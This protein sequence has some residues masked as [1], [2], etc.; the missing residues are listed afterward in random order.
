MPRALALPLTFVTLFVLPACGP[1]EASGSGGAASSGS[2]Q[3]SGAGGQ[4]GDAGSGGVGGGGS[5][6]GGRGGAPGPSAWQTVL[7]AQDLDGAVLSIWGASH[8]HVF[9]VGGP[10]GNDGFET[11][12]VHFDGATWKR[13]S[14][15]GAETYWWVHGTG[16]DDVWFVGEQGR[17]THWDGASFTEH[18]S[19]V[20]AT[21]WG[22]MA[23]SKTEA[24]AV[25]GTPGGGVGAPNDIVLRWDGATWTPEPLPGAPLGRT[26]YKIWGS[27]PED[28]YAVGEKGT[29]WRKKGAAWSLVEPA[30]TPGKLLTVSG[31]GANEVY[32]VGGAVVL[33]LDGDGFSEVN[34]SL[35]NLVSGV[36]CGP[37][38]SA[39]LVGDGGQ[40]QRLVDGAWIDE[41]V[42]EPY[43]DLHAAWS[44]GEGSFWAVGGDFYAPKAAG[45]RRKGVVARYGPGTLPGEVQ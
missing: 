12:V 40:K 26:L 31:C 43:D 1:S 2:Q 32:T 18:A 39:L 23:F 9:A 38:G 13:L 30:P 34:I 35:T 44:D 24:F 20:E 17:I 14:P 41:F 25:G 28:L 27:T 11:L 29:I 15:G 22:V 6:V 36:A 7:D 33:R 37:S 42:I 45:V 8:S 4:G 5:G 19:G 16:P 3:S 21:L 10:L